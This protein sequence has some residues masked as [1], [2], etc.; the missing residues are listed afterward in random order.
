MKE[1]VRV[2]DHITKRLPDAARIEI[3]D[4]NG[5]KI[6]VERSSRA[7]ADTPAPAV[8]VPAAASFGPAA[9]SPA[10]VSTEPGAKITSP[11]VGTFYA[12]PSPDAEP[13][14]KVGG[15]V[16][17]GQPLCIIE[18]MKAMNEIESEFDGTVTEICAQNGALVE[19]GQTLFVIE[20]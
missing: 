16:K 15:R 3:T 4:E 10:P 14:A 6:L 5:A 1:I 13:F 8:S 2:F 17:K 7:A 18:A 12:A 19:F 11:L 9:G 20:L